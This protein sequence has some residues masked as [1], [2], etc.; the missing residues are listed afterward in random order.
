MRRAALI[1]L[2]LAC[3]GSSTPRGPQP[4]NIEWT[5]L[6]NSVTTTVAAGTAVQWHAADTSHTVTPDGTP[7]P[8]DVF[9]S[10]GSTSPAQ[11]ITAPGTYH[12]HCTIHSN[13]HGTLVVQ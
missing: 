13:M 4:V 10:S 6:S 9:I 11:T 7:P 3:G 12:Y 5:V 2:V 1:A 8:G